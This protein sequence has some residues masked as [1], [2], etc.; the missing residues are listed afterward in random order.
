MLIFMMP[1]LGGWRR[2]DR[3]PTPAATFRLPRFT[4]EAIPADEPDSDDDGLVDLAEGVYG[5]DPRDADSDGDGITDGLEASQGTNPLDGILV[6][7]GTIASTMTP[8]A[9]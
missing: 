8:G 9:V 3:T 5:T 4:L 2:S 1:R 7:N 6:S